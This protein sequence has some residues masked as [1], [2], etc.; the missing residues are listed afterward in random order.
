VRTVEFVEYNLSLSTGEE[1]T[2]SELDPESIPSLTDPVVV[3]LADAVLSRCTRAPRDA[4]E[5][6]K[7]GLPESLEA[8]LGT[9]PGGCLLKVSSPV[10]A[11]LK[12]CVISDPVRCS[13]R[14]RAK[15]GG[16]DFPMCWTFSVPSGGTPEQSSQARDL[17]DS[18]V[19]AWRDGRHVVIADG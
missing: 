4:L 11:E 6:A 8:H 7:S 13:T 18:I 16:P 19:S 12:F 10:C 3:R 17:A 1:I 14:H 9:P 2:V 5:D 15:R